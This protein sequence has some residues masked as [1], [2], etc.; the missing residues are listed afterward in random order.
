MHVASRSH[1]EALC[2]RLT[3]VDALQPISVD[4]FFPNLNGEKLLL[5]LGVAAGGAVAVVVVVVAV[6]VLARRLHPSQF[7][8]QNAMD[9]PYFFLP[10]TPRVSASPRS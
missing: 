4:F 1:Q 9:V 7:A 2:T 3:I 5:F 6:A 10:W 8:S